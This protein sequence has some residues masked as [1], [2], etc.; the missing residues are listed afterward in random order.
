MKIMVKKIIVFIIIKLFILT[1]KAKFLKI[2][3]PNYEENFLN[4][5]NKLVFLEPKLQEKLVLFEKELKENPFL[6]FNC[7]LSQEIRELKAFSQTYEKKTYYENYKKKLSVKQKEWHIQM[8]EALM[9]K[10]TFKSYF[11]R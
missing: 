11:I 9:G 2:M 1:K 7:L 5:P 10:K 4:D 6:N 3:M 8:Q